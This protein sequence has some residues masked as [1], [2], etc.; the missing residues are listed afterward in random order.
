MNTLFMDLRHAFRLFRKMPGFTLATLIVLALGIGANTAIFSLVYGVLIRPLP[1]AEP[2]RLVQLWHLPPQK[3]FPGMTRFALS[4][5]NYL[6]WEQQNTVFEWSAIY[7]STAFRLG[8]N[9]DPQ[10][11]QASRVEPTFFSALGVK[12]LFGRVIAQGDDQGAR[13]YEVVLS[14]RLWTSQFGANP[15]IVGQSVQLNGEAYTVIGVMPPTFAIPGYAT[16]WTP[17][18]WDP[19]ERSVRGEHHFGAIARLK[20]GVTVEGAQAQLQTIAA[21]L[22]EQYPEDNAGWGAKVVSMREQTTGDVR[23][24]LLVLLGAVAFVLLIACANV[25]NMMLAKTMDRRREVAIC[26][27]LGATRPRILRQMICEAVLLALTGGALGLIVADSGTTLVLKVLGS[28][29]PRLFEITID[30]TVLGFTVA[31]AVATGIAAGVLPAWKLANSDPHEALKQGGRTDAA[32]AGKRMRNA[33]VVVEVALSLILLVGA[34]L[35]IR[36]FWNLRSVYPGFDPDHVA[37]M[38][39][40]AMDY[41]T[42]EEESAFI[43]EVLRR[44]RAVPGVESAGA[45]DSLP[46]DG[47][48]N[49]PVAIEGQPALAM[50]D[51]PEVSVRLITGGYFKSMRIPLVR[52]RDFTDADGP[53]APKVVVVSE[54]FAKRFW[55]DQDPIGRRLTLTFFPASVRQV[56][57][58]VGDVKIDGVTDTEPSPTLYW[59]TTQLYVPE[60]FGKFRGF[61]FTLAVRTLR[62]PQTAAAEI[63]TVI[64]ELSPNTPLGKVQTMEERLADSIAPRRFNM[65]LLATFAG[66][67]LLL[68]AVG[69]YSVLAYAVRQRVHEIGVRMA[70]GADLHDVLRMVVIEGMRPALLGVAIGAVASIELSRL[71]SSLIY[72]VRATDAATFVTVSLLLCGVAFASSILPAFAATKVDPLQMLRDE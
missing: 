17:L 27:A 37:T 68:A 36:T 19:V 43:D 44:I 14:H 21:R 26:T 40:S 30:R 13:H 9:G 41:R 5:A 20:S 64:H 48:S 54:S 3:S 28:S 15:G 71:L 24:P 49:Q 29:L 67:A 59:P 2:D 33:L 58:V 60:R 35:M 45:V 66:L 4:A 18:V 11:L 8:G 47:G 32:S 25:A 61:R 72:G 7:D 16:L 52:G 57:G 31:I 22:A 38:V 6:D 65:L 23:T 39:A 69:I 42:T 56:V 51:Q 63:R 10:L 62:D 12:P 50:A 53:S 55:P 70:L 34:G 46:L 1:F